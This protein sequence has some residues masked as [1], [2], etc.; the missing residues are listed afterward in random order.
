M[1]IT[2]ARTGIDGCWGFPGRLKRV[3]ASLATANPSHPH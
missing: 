2:E 1:T 3:D